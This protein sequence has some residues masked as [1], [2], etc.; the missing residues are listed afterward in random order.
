MRPLAGEEEA[1]K[2]YSHAIHD[3][4]T[5]GDAAVWASTPAPKLAIGYWRL[6][7]DATVRDVIVAVRA[8]EASHSH[9]NHTMS[10]MAARPHIT[11]P[12]FFHLV[13]TR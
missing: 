6:A 4:D 9:V 12:L 1:V 2:T 7:E 5:G 11:P 8:D 13:L 3:I 10:S